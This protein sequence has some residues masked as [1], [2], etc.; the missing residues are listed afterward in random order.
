MEGAEFRDGELLGGINAGVAAE[1]VGDDA[2]GGDVEAVAG[3]EEF[4][5][6][7]GGGERGVGGPGEDG[8]EADGGE[9]TDGRAERER[10]RVAECGT[11][12]KQGGHFAAFETGGEGDDGDLAILERGEAAVAV[13]CC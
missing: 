3:A 10:E 1:A 4:H 13:G 7:Q 11:D 6:E 2:G 5:A 9:H 12:E 8:D